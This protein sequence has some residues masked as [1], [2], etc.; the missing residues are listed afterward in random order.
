[1]FVCFCFRN[2]NI[3]IHTYIHRYTYT[4]IHAYTHACTHAR[5]HTH[6]HT[7]A[8]THT[9]KHTVVETLFVN[10][11]FPCA[12]ITWSVTFCLYVPTRSVIFLLYFS[13]TDVLLD[14]WV[15]GYPYEYDSLHRSSPWKKTE[16]RLFL[17]LIISI[18][19]MMFGN[20]P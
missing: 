15:K 7:H 10:C 5:T 4:H 19:L 12:T 1:M 20:V 6:P 18:Q 16:V 8:H 11:C 3:H 2:V 14:C 13:V 9:H 17:E